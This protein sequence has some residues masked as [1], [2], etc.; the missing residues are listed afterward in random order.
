MAQSPGELRTYAL[1]CCLLI[2]SLGVCYCTIVRPLRLMSRLESLL[3]LVPVYGF[4]QVLPLPLKVVRIL[5][6]AR[7]KLADA[8]QPV[9]T[10]SRW[11]PI[12][13]TPSATLYHCLLFSACAS[14]VFVVYDLSKRFS[15]RPWIVTLPLIAVGI[16]Q[17]IIGLVQASVRYR[18]HSD[19]HVYY[20]KPLCGSSGNDSAVCGG[21]CLR[22]FRKLGTT[23]KS[24]KRVEELPRSCSSAAELLSLRC[25]SRQSSRPY[26]GRALLPRWHR[27][28][29]SRLQDLP[30]DCPHT[31]RH[32][33]SLRQWVL[34]YCWLFCCH[35]RNSLPASVTFRRNGNDRS[36]AWR[37]TL[38]LIEAYPA[39]G[40]G[41]GAYESSFLAFKHSAPALTQDYAHNDYLQ[42][43][44]ELGIVGFTIVLVPLGAIIFKLLRGLPNP[45]S[46]LSWLS[47]ACAASLLAIGIHS[48]VDFNLYVPANMFV[49]AWILGIAAYAGECEKLRMA[50]ETRLCDEQMRR[51]LTNSV[52][53]LLCSLCFPALLL[54]SM[55]VNRE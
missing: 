15:H 54:S 5:S 40:C 49:F 12:S 8:L 19:G 10:P 25:C 45:R 48:C 36:P 11:V 42:Y 26:P 43:L 38:K 13:A 28:F 21:T 16:A 52:I 14:V 18:Q 31:K 46:E 50:P 4:C 17:A 6:P 47:L 37:D 30:G 34:R 23:G 9:V 41:L 39:I 29:S 35:R 53:N 2:G 7:A 3:F 20:Q 44:A 27:W 33:Q 24:S 22:G 55:E 1:I 51:G 32:G